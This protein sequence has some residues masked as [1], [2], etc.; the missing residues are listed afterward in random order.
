MSLQLR[1]PSVFL[2]RISLILRSFT[3]LSYVWKKYSHDLVLS[4]ELKEV[5]WRKTRF[6]LGIVACS[7][8]TRDRIIFKNA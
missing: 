8:L 7:K 3:E 2:F 5:D 1:G 4:P 6:G